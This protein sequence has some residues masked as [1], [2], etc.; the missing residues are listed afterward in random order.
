MPVNDAADFDGVE[1]ASDAGGE[2]QKLVQ[3]NWNMLNA[4]PKGLTLQQ[5]HDDEPLRDMVLDF[6]NRTDIRMIQ[7]RSPR[8]SPK[9]L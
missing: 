7:R 5:L 1:T 6:M 3:R 4:I 9:T 8:R 2:F